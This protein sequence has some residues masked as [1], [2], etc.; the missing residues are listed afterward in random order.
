MIASKAAT[1]F[2]VNKFLFTCSQAITEVPWGDDGP[3][4]HLRQVTLCPEK[5]GL[6]PP[7]PKSWADSLHP[8]AWFSRYEAG[9]SG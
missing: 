5:E 1:L 6:T 7:R 4:C 3:V 2:S 8:P 9:W